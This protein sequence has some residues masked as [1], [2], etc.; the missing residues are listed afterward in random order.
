MKVFKLENEPKITN[1]FKVPDAYFDAFQSKVTPRLVAKEVPVI[2]L[3]ALRKTWILTI[4]AIFIIALSVTLINV[5]NTSS[6]EIDKAT[7]ENYLANN[8]SIS[9]DD[10]VELLDEDDIKKIKIDLKIEDQTLEDIL[11]TNS[12]IEDYIVD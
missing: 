3:F 10:I 9:N 4:A 8:A 2:S 12:N 11:T 1:G 6:S 5:M 7:L